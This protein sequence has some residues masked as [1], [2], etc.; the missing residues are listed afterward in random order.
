MPSF[1][2]PESKRISGYGN[3]RKGTITYKIPKNEGWQ[4]SEPQLGSQ[5]PDAGEELYYLEPTVDPQVAYDLVNFH[6]SKIKNLYIL[7]TLAN[8]NESVPLN[9]R[10]GYIAA[11]EN[12]LCV[13]DFHDDKT[14]LPDYYATAKNLEDADGTNYRWVSGRSNVP[15]S[16]SVLPGGDEKLKKVTSISNARVVV[17]EVWYFLDASE[18]DN[19][20][21]GLVN[22]LQQPNQTHDLPADDK[23]WRCTTATTEKQGGYTLLRMRFEFK[24]YTDK[25][26]V[27]QGWDPDLYD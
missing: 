19:L 2:Q 1:E 26:D 8:A 13:S 23:Y 9:E 3:T 17:N 6:Y 24:A 7:S 14:T 12:R 5:W 15:A 20:A 10:S 25:D 4:S 27:V 22:T 21:V 18:A 11:W 16:Y